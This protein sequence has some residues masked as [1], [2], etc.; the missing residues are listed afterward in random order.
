MAPSKPQ[1]QEEVLL[2]HLYRIWEELLKT[3]LGNLRW[4]SPLWPL[5]DVGEAEK[6][7]RKSETFFVEGHFPSWRQVRGTLMA[8]L[9][10]LDMFPRSLQNLVDWYLIHL[11]N[12]IWIFERLCLE[13]TVWDLNRNMTVFGVFMRWWAKGA[14]LLVS[15][16]ATHKRQR[17][18]FKTF[19]KGLPG[20]RGWSQHKDA[21]G[22]ISQVSGYLRGSFERA[23]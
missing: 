12:S 9:G 10:K 5:K 8:P 21:G 7:S 6:Q 3:S 19:P 18:L 13:L 17:E 11:R 4:P 23:N 2:G 15:D 22:K 16:V 20:L 14:S 1:H